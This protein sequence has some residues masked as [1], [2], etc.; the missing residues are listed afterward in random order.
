MHSQSGIESIK[1]VKE[2]VTILLSDEASGK[3]DGQKVFQLTNQYGRMVG[4]GMEGKSL[5]WSFTRKKGCYRKMV[6]CHL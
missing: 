2:E 5:K 3:I 6:K 4:L 1:Q